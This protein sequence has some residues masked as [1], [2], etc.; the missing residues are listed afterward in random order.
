ML[1]P[2]PIRNHGA[3]CPLVASTLTC[4]RKTH[5]L[6]SQGKTPRKTGPG[7]PQEAT[8]LHP[9]YAHGG[10]PERFQDLVAKQVEATIP[11]TLKS[12]TARRHPLHPQPR[13]FSQ[14]SVLCDDRTSPAPRETSAK[15]EQ[16]GPYTLGQGQGQ[17]PACSSGASV[18]KGTRRRVIPGGPL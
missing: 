18:R 5:L 13:G 12:P 2:Q 6:P 9:T 15:M 4:K 14:A 1:K 11:G 7:K 16:C 3:C 17:L 10:H 8:C